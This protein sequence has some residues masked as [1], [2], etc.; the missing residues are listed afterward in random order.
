MA[1]LQDLD[2]RIKSVTNTKKITKAMEMVAAAKLRRAQQRIERLRPFADSLVELTALVAQGIQSGP[3]HPLLQERELTKGCIVMYT[4]DRGLSGAVNSNA[5]RRSLLLAEEWKADGADVHWIAIGKKGVGSLKF[6]KIEVDQ[7]F[8][9]MSD[10]PTFHDAETVGRAICKRFT[11]GEYDRVTMVYNHFGSAVTQEIVVQQLLP[12]DNE[13]LRAATEHLKLERA[14]R[15]VDE[16][17]FGALSHSHGNLGH[18]STPH[19]VRDIQESHHSTEVPRHKADWIFEPDTETLLDRLLPTYVEQSIF[20]GLLEATA[21]QHGAQMTA[22]RNASENAGE[23]ID[24]VTLQ[25][26]RAR[27]ASITQQILEVVAGADALS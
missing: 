7:A 26:N 8:R 20:R 6:R 25:K 17:S 1:T 24:Q 11:V 18:A 3:Q 9:G 2:R 19:P 22:M 27:Q 13:V 4:G 5:L 14:K 21:S 12:I 23:I 10:A 16:D 15:L